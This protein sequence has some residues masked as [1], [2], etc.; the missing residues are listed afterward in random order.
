[1]YLIINDSTS[2]Q[3]NLA[4]EEYA[5][6][7]T[8]FEA[9][10]LWRNSKA[11][12]I[13]CNQNAV[14]EIDLEYTRKYDIPVIRRQSG[15]G[16]VFHDLGNVNFTV[17]QN[18]RE[19]DFNNYDLFTS[20]IIGF[21]ATLGVHGERQGRNDLAVDGAKFCG[22]AQAAKKGRIMHHGCILYSADFSDLVGSLRPRDIKFES[23]G[24]KSVRKRVTNLIDHMKSPMPVEEFLSGLAGYFMEHTP[25]IERYEMTP[26]DIASTALLAREKY[27]TWDWNFGKSPS[28][29]MERSRRYDFGI[30]DLKLFVEG[31]MIEDMHIYGDFFGTEDRGGLEKAMRGT[32]HDP[33]AIRAAMEDVGIGGYIAGMTLDEWI[34]LVY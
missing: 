5:L 32:R 18:V 20:P 25:G 2:P 12:I 14:E 22:N 7:G 9:V 11:V 8:D 1:M 26:E 10:V 29:N 33:S 19:G 23:H 31:G 4:F 34:D 16:A 24:V 17:I 28:Y 3:F 15:G 30:V 27:S 6:T 21:L 13:G